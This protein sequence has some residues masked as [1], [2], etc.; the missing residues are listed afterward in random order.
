MG[1]GLRWT[2]EATGG[3]AAVPVLPDRGVHA[4]AGRVLARGPRGR[5]LVLPAGD[6][7][8]D[9]DR[10]VRPCWPGRPAQRLLSAGAVP[11][12]GLTA[13]LGRRSPGL[14]AFCLQ[15]AE[16][17]WR[18]P[19]SWG[20]ATGFLTFRGLLEAPPRGKVWLPGHSGEVSWQSQQ[21]TFTG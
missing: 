9:G 11:E 2:P 5:A 13:S 6:S 17:A 18:F 14:D 10:K 1:E 7:W 12:S 3:P 4:G 20:R 8:K 19:P 16:M 21:R 15:K